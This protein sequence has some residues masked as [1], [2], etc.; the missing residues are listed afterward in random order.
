MEA[1]VKHSGRGPRASLSLRQNQLHHR[2]G[3][4]ALVNGVFKRSAQLT[5][6]D[7]VLDLVSLDGRLALYARHKA[8]SGG[9]I[10]SVTDTDST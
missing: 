2:Q 8:C 10:D 1:Q 5:P 4:N 6:R 7:G 9:Y 3:L